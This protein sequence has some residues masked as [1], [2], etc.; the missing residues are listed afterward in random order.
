MGWKERYREAEF[1]GIKFFVPNAEGSGGRRKVV[2]ELPE[3]DKPQIRDMGRKARRF[4]IDAYVLGENYDLAR[5]VLISALE[6]K[7]PGKLV[8][9]YIGNMIVDILDYSY[10]ETF[11]ETEICR[12]SLSCIESGDITFPASRVNTQQAVQIAKTEAIENSKL[13]FEN[14]YILINKPTTAATAAKDTLDKALNSIDKAKAT[15]S[16]DSNY[17][18]EIDTLKGKVISLA[19]D[20]VELAQGVTQGIT[21]GTNFTDENAVTTENARS[22]YHDMQK[23][24]DF[25]PTEIVGSEIELDPAH[26]I[27]E[28]TRDNAVINAAGLLGVMEYA[29]V[30]EALNLQNLVL[31]Y[32]DP[33]LDR[34]E[35]NLYYLALYNLR[36]K[37]V[38][39]IAV[40]IKTLPV[41]MESWVSI[42]LPALV[43]SYDLYGNI[44]SES[45]IVSRN[46]MDHPGFSPGSTR[47]K[48]LSN[49]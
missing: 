2:D 20:V 48:V 46:V 39:D 29:S 43:I 26:L 42:S 17:Q 12:F 4:T 41:V 18:W 35:D 37:A 40:R 3:R 14:L 38:N 33:M 45:D 6:K 31:S 22:N 5:D 10:R 8:H 19:Y 9:P 47:L 34:V 25:E 13:N 23:L 28:L 1:R 44:D 30:D 16:S 15:I 49:A 21:F 7:G 24:F 32:L 27:S 36:T 11:R